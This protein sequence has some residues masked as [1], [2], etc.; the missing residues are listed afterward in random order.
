MIEQKYADYAWEKAEELLSIGS[1]TGYTAK[2]TAWLLE[3]FE[4]LGFPARLTTKG[5]VLVDLE[6]ENVRDS[7]MLAAH[8]D[9]LGAMVCQ[10]KSDGRLKLS[11]LLG[12]CQTQ[13]LVALYVEVFLFALELAA[14][15]AHKC[16]S[17]AVSLVHVSL[18]F[19]YKG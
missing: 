3:V 13:G 14:A 11:Q 17:V 5:G 8:T 10:I 4:G 9:T 12:L 6:G 7:L 18:N 1:P 2:A 19:E 16:N 15:D